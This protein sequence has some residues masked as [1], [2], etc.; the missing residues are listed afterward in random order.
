MESRR[1][2]IKSIVPRMVGWGALL[3][4]DLSLAESLLAQAA[5]SSSV[6]LDDPRY[7]ALLKELTQEYRF[8]AS[9][10]KTL[11]QKVVLQPPIIEKFERP[12]EILP[13]Y[14]YRKRFIKDE[15]IVRGQAYLQENLKLL[16][17]IEET[18]GV[19][20]EIICSILGIETKF[21]QKGIEKHRVFDVLNTAYTLYPR[22]ERFYRDELIAF[23][24]LCREEKRDPFSINGSYAGAFGL[25][26][27]MPTSFR[28]YAVDFDKD[29]KRDLWISKEDVFASVANYLKTFG[30]KRN[31]LTYLPA[32]PSDNTPDAI[33]SIQI[34]IRK[35]I[36]L[37]K[38]TEMGIE[39]SL[40]EN[41]RMDE[42]VS[43]ALYQPAEGTETLLALF[44][45]F[46]SITYY[47][48]SLNYG[49]VISD[50]SEI[51]SKRE[52]G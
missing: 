51:L 34:G 21:G 40:P 47:N 15:L 33:K 42:A 11:F 41:T 16:Q 50:F 28:K 3:S 31:G 38:A 2:F 19:G 17:A 18:Y 43:F 44:E 8:K 52:N 46:R 29:G 12:P 27:F 24:L 30:W 1:T 25:P 23:L 49:L 39:I 22:R 9:D 5:P 14:E 10:L 20:K 32:R 7:V 36:P 6:N 35:T 26:Q 37:N 4:I 13:Y 45:N 48:Y